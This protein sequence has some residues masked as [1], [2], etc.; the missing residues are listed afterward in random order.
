MLL[1]KEAG[2]GGLLVLESVVL[3]VVDDDRQVTVRI[4]AE[5]TIVKEALEQNIQQLRMELKGAGLEVD[6][7]EV[8]LF[9]E[10]GR[11]KER[12]ESPASMF[13]EKRGAGNSREEEGASSERQKD[14]RNDPADTHEGG[15]NYFV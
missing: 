10:S 2:Y 4:M 15:I 12:Q 14:G 8:Q 11:E 5:A 3:P 9:N 1:V 7:F 6:K 13:S